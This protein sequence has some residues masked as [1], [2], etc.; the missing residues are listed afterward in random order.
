[1]TLGQ[2]TKHEKHLTQDSPQLTLCGFLFNK[3]SVA[4]E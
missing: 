1:M 4:F 2:R 3:V